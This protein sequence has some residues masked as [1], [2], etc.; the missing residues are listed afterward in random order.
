MDTQKIKIV[1]HGFPHNNEIG[2]VDQECTFIQK[3]DTYDSDHFQYLTFKTM[4]IDFD[5]NDN[6]DSFIRLS[7][8]DPFVYDEEKTDVA[9]FWSCDGPEEIVE[10]F[11]EFARRAGMTCRWKVEKYNITNGNTNE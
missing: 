6:T 2:V 3:S 4:G 1:N 10:L 5:P 11:N 7:T 9:P 8:G